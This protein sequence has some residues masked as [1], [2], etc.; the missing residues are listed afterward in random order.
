MTILR[1]YQHIQRARSPWRH[2]LE[3]RQVVNV[4]DTGIAPCWRRRAIS[5]VLIYGFAAA[6]PWRGLR[7]C[8][9]NHR[10]EARVRGRTER[11][12]RRAR[13]GID[14]TSDSEAASRRDRLVNTR[15]P[16]SGRPAD[17]GSQVLPGWAPPFVGCAT[18]GAESFS[19]RIRAGLCAG[20]KSAA[21]SVSSGYPGAKV[22]GTTVISCLADQIPCR[23]LPGK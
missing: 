16:C 12:G 9:P 10:Y 4:R 2:K 3:C 14:L 19:A 23:S 8:P 17:S 13:S 15:A 21:V 22:G 11:A 5:R 18:A 20:C 6:C 7:A 1:G